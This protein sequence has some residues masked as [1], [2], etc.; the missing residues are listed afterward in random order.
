MWQYNV[1]FATNPN[2]HKLQKYSNV[3]GVRVKH[4]VCH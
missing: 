1:E 4:E 2:K 3:F